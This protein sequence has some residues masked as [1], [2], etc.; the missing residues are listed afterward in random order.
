MKKIL[1]VDD[2]EIMLMLAERALGSHYE[3]ILAHSGAEAVDLYFKDQPDLVLTDLRMPEMSGYELQS[4]IHSRSDA[5]TPFIFITSDESDESESR[6]FDLGAADYIRKPIKAEVLLKRIERVLD[7]VDEN[8]RLRKE[9]Q[10]DAMTG[11]YNKAT[12]ERI[13]GDIVSKKRGMLL[14]LD[15]DSFKLINDIHGHEMGDRI[16]IV[17]SELIKSSIRANDIAGRIGGDEFVVFCENLFDIT[18]IE[19]KVNVYNEKLLEAARAYMGQDMNIPLG[20]SCGATKVWDLTQ[21]YL[22][23]FSKA[24][25]ALYKAKQ[26]GKHCTHFYEKDSETESEAA[27][28]DFRNLKM[29]FGERNQS[30]GAFVTDTESFKT[31]YRFMVRLIS[32]YQV[33]TRMVIFTLTGSEG[34]ELSDATEKFM[35]VATSNLRSSDVVL[36]HNHNQVIMLI[37]KVDVEKY[38][39]PVMRV[40]AAWKRDGIHGISVGFEAEQLECDV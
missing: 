4:T 3:T 12:T 6:G 18:A 39:I 21:D 11:L 17:F 8:N 23:V 37:M 34:Q 28:S 30:R 15:L 16:L 2:E 14:V 13:L 26:E 20:C 36:K 19:Q 35:D 32:N 10:L 5:D 27:I 1:I 38:T 24:D 9:A 22:T 33:D 40:L 25:A 29:I 31:I 7:N